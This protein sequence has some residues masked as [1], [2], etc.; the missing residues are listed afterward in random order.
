MAT[1]VA[2]VCGRGRQIVVVI[3][4]AERTR[5]IS[6][7]VGQQ[8]SGRAVVEFCVLPGVKCMAACAVRGGKFRSRGLMLRICRSQPIRHV[9]S[10]A[11]RRQPDV[12]SHRG[13]LVAFIALHD[14]VCAE[15]RKPV[16]VV[17][18]R[19]RGSLPA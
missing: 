12:I 3:Y 13:I 7:A 16:E 17:L 15:Q 2:A 18:D 19:L 10:R 1:G 4:V 14:C 6:M 8:E 11:R 5:H 9:A